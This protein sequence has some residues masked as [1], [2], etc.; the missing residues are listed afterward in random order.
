MSIRSSAVLCALLPG[1]AASQGPD[2]SMVLHSSTFS[3]RKEQGKF[4]AELFSA[5]F[6]QLDIFSKGK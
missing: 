2:L 6:Q 3:N 5:R 4:P 1:S